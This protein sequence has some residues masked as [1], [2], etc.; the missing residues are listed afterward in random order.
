MSTGHAHAVVGTSREKTGVGTIAVGT[1]V[2]S[3]V[4]TATPTAV[5]HRRRGHVRNSSGNRGCCSCSRGVSV[6]ASMS[7]L[8]DELG[9]GCGPALTPLGQAAPAEEDREDDGRGDDEPD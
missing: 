7:L 1:A 3:T 6:R 2:T 4:S 9:G 8:G 5:S